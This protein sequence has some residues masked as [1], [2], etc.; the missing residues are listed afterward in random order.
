MQWEQLDGMLFI[1]SVHKQLLNKS[2]LLGQVSHC[3]TV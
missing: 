2:T 1:D 3:V